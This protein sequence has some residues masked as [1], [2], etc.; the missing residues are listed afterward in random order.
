MSLLANPQY[1][2]LFALLPFIVWRLYT[3]TR[4]L[5]G[6]QRSVAWR[7]WSA[8]IG[9][10]SLILLLL[11]AGVLVDGTAD[12]SLIAGL[13]AGTIL[14]AVNVRLTKFEH[15]P[16][17]MFYTPNAYIGFGL[18]F[19]IVGRI[20]FRLLTLFTEGLPSN[21]TNVK[22][23]SSPAT[24]ILAGLLIGYFAGFAVGVLLWRRK[25]TPPRISSAPLSGI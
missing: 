6:R 5:M 3:R 17:G 24:M 23:A 7:H 22:D 15:T 20:S 1:L 9:F 12:L 25:Q 21:A 8:A 19:V 16:D 10:P 14:A 2:L 4:R 18:V 11:A 13:S